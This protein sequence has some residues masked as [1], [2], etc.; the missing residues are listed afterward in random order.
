[1]KDWQIVG[2]SILSSVVLWIVWKIIPSG[3][4]VLLVMIYAGLFTSLLFLNKDV[5][6][7]KKG[8]KA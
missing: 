1:M 3:L 4:D 7:L 5:Q 2:A 8:G 6:E